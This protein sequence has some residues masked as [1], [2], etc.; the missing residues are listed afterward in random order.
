MAVTAVRGSPKSMLSE[1]GGVNEPYRWNRF[2]V[3]G[4]VWPRPAND[5]AP[6]HGG[7]E[8]LGLATGIVLTLVSWILVLQALS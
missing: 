4:R 3:S 1:R 7:Y 6:I 5:N 8:A 2:I